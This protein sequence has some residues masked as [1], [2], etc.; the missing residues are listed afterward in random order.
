LGIRFRG[1]ARAAGA[2]CAAIGIGLAFGIV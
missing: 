2:A 1:L